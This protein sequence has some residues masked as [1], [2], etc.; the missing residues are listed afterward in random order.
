MFCFV[1]NNKY[2]KLAI[3]IPEIKGIDFDVILV[4]LTLGLYRVDEA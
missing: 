1:F 3:D 2:R 4:E